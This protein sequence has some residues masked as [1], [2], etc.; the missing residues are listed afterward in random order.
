MTNNHLSPV[1]LNDA[2]QAVLDV[3]N[4][5]AH[6]KFKVFP[7]K[8]SEQRLSAAIELEL[9]RMKPFKTIHHV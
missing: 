4:D 2:V 1:D 7:S 5:Q 9:L 8:E 6:L 3:F